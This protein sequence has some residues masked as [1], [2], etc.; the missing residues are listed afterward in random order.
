M[1]QLIV[2]GSGPAGY[3]AAL[4]AA[5]ANLRPL[6]I[7]S[8]VEAG[9]DLMNTT[10]VENFPG[11]PEGVMGPDLMDKMQ[12]QAEKF[13]TEVLFDDVTSVDLTGDIKTVTLSSGERH[14]ALAVVFATGSAYRK[15]GLADEDRLSGRG[16][17]WCAT[18]DGFF[19]RDRTVAVVGGGDS[20]LE[21]ATFLTRF[22]SKVYVIHR[23]D[24]LRASQ[25]MQDRA[26]A[27]D[28]IEFLWNAEVTAIHSADSV[29][30]VTLTDT[31]TGEASELPVEGLFVAI[32]ADPRV[33][34][35]HGQ[36]DLTA[37]GTIAVDG[38]SSRTNLPGVF[39]AGD[40]IDPTYRQAVT[41]AAS[42]TV[43]ALDAEHFLTTLPD[44]LL[45]RTTSDRTGDLAAA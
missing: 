32:G 22:A 27:N 13:G 3:T 11:F 24:S 12:R 25:A 19:F 44:E 16:V 42:G 31:T 39:A 29:T 23:R 9:G 17:S 20:A 35:V 4:Y 45:R 18:C 26:R 15:L 38:R 43:A 36:L 10:E 2:I 28:K 7:A 34:L 37:D 5:R 14:Q 1:R 33:H 8:S 41:A 30:G 6:L 40:V 21:E